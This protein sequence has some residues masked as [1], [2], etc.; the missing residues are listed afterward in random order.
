MKKLAD[1]YFLAS[2]A[3][4][5][6]YLVILA[7]SIVRVTGSGMGCPDWPKCFGYVIPP[8][9]QEVLTIAAGK[10]FHQGQMVIHHDTLWVAQYPVV[11]N[12]QLDF[13]NKGSEAAWKKYQKHD[14]AIFNPVHTWIEYINRLLTGILGFPVLL[15]FVMALRDGVKTK[16]WSVSFWSGLTLTFML[17]EAWLGKLVVD[18]ELSKGKV[19]LHML[20]SLGI[21]IALMKAR[22]ESRANRVPEVN[23]AKKWWIIGMGLVLC[24]MILGTQLREVVDQVIKNGWERN[25]WMDQVL[26][27]GERMVFY[28]H[29]TFS[30]VL[31]AYLFW[32]A[33]GLIKI[34]RKIWANALMMV[35][36]AETILGVLLNY[37]EFPAFAQPTHLLL[38][39]VLFGILLNGFLTKSTHIG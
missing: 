26:L 20:G 22:S 30:W 16:K 19:T 3:L 25:Q 38:S 31:V 18:G 17:Y 4:V 35:V 7:G 11:I 8:T 24:Q 32:L 27:S 33:S 9:D 5:C 13:F 21:V 2:I 15:L 39:F 28:I 37:F 10:S 6:V 14:Y 23:L 1:T 29:R 12:D 36:A 34:K